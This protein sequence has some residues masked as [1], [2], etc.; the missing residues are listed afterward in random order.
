MK[1]T[2]YVTTSITYPNAKP[3]IGHTLEWVQADF[4]SRYFASSGLEVRFLTGTDE[5]G[6]KMQQAAAKQGL[7]EVEYADQQ[8]MIFQNLADR[9]DIGY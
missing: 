4:I 2:A 5:H 3:H 6:L 1:S 7:S 9:L 8:Y